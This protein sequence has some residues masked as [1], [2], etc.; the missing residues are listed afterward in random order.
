MGWLRERGLISSWEDYRNLPA[1]V[2]HDA[3]MVM[4]HESVKRQNDL[5]TLPRRGRR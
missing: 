4:Y 5:K 3:R 1:G 2:L